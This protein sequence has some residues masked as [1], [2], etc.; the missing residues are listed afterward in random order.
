MQRCQGLGHEALAASRSS[1]SMPLDIADRR[2]LA[3]GIAAVKPDVV[4]NC[5]AIAGIEACEAEPGRAYVVNAAPVGELAQLS[6]GNGFKI[7]HVSTDHFFTGD[8]RALHDEN[9]P[10]TLLNEYAKTKYAAECFAAL[11]P[12][13]LVVRTAF[14]GRSSARDRG[15]AEDIY[16]ALR[17][18][19]QLT[20]FEDAYTSLLHRSAVADAMLR[21]IE[22]DARGVFNVASRDVFSKADL[23]RAF[24]ARLGLPL[25]A[26]PGSVSSLKAPRGESLG[27]ATEKIAAALGGAHAGFR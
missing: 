10:V 21:L 14:V 5:A 19:R 12:D 1:A 13:A 17:A 8:G 3:A 4:V 25:N 27:L 23:I 2:Q 26:K 18:G 9:A 15:F 6:R 24:A 11:A 20:L 7:A 22:Q 16:G